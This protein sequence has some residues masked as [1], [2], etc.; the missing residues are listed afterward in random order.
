ML[1]LR[2]YLFSSLLTHFP[3]KEK[4]IIFFPCCSPGEDLTAPIRN[5]CEAAQMCLLQEPFSWWWQKPGKIPKI[6][7]GG[8]FIFFSPISFQTKRIREKETWM[9]QPH[10]N[11][12]SLYYFLFFFFFLGFQK[13]QIFPIS[14][15]EIL[16]LPSPGPHLSIRSFL[17]LQDIPALSLSSSIC[18]ILYRNPRPCLICLGFAVT[19][20]RSTFKLDCGIRAVPWDER[21]AK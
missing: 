4:P 14:E 16:A 6:K 21:T 17:W 18:S 3:I 12:K 1:S 19:T 5:G 2:N 10:I 20:R 11:E 7:I 9:H 15:K 13:R 8:G